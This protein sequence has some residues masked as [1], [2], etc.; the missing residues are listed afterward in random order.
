M[1][2]RHL[3]KKWDASFSTQTGFVS[4]VEGW[5]AT[6]ARTW[7]FSDRCYAQIERS[8]GVETKA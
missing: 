7:I 3:E 6:F 8:Y 2:I 1:A 4:N 5:E